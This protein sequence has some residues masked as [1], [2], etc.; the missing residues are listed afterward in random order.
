MQYKH[1]LSL[2]IASLAMILSACSGKDSEPM[3]TD[4]PRPV[5]TIVVEDPVSGGVRN[6][7]ARIDSYK[8]T[9]LSF[10]VSGI[11][12]ELLIKEGERVESGQVIAK[13]DPMDY[14]IVVDGR[15]AS[16]ENARKNFD[17]ANELIG[18][19]NISKMDYD[20]L[21]AGFKNARA[22]LER[23]RQDLEH[24]VLKAPFNGIIA[25]RHIQQFEEVRPMQTVLELQYIDKLDVKFDIAE[26]IVR[27]LRAN[28]KNRGKI[29]DHIIAHASFADIPNKR[30]PLILKELA[31]RAAPQTQTFEVTYTMDRPEGFTVL[32]GMTATVTV[33][34]SA[35][36]HNR[37]PTFLLPASAVAGDYKLA[38][39]VWVVDEKAMTVNAQPVKVG[40]MFGGH[41]EVFE[42][43]KPGMRIVT[44]GAAFVTEGMK[45]TLLPDREQ[46]EPRSTEKAGQ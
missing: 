45:I 6:F 44:A 16:F 36:L 15:K 14:Q 38:P 22:A 25:K 24:T 19:G 31:T 9:E 34:M 23:A 43:V 32:P 29:R 30:F 10:R 33:D 13:L 4:V 21:E 12:Q 3:E 20:K 5:K 11:V 7:P 26:S 8:K 35:L 39:R 46:A 18:S 1:L 28:T 27:S 40:Q 42:G 17:R 37:E 2:F 41:I